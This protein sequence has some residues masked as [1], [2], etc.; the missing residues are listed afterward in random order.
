MTRLH[1]LLLKIA[2]LTLAL[3]AAAAAQDYP[4]KPVRLIVP[5][6]PG[7]LNDVVGR[8]VAMQLSEKLG[9]K[10]IVENRT[11]AGGVVGTEMLANAA[12]DGYTLGITSIA[13]AVHPAL[14]KLSYDSNKAFAPVAF[15]ASIPNAFAV[16]LK[17]PANSVKEFIALAK[18]KPGQLQYVS[19]GAGGSLHLAFELFKDMAGIDVLHI[20]FKGANPA[21][22]NLVGGHSDA[23][24]GSVSSV[25]PHIRAGKVRGLA[26]TSKQRSSALPDT[27][28]FAEAGMPDYGGGNWIGISAPAGTPAPVI[29]KLNKAIA[30]ILK[31]PEVQK[32][33]EARG[34]TADIMSPAEFSKHIDSETA[35][36]GRV[37][38]A[39]GIKAE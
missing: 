16:S 9:K 39:T 27:P 24:I 26:V 11:G 29:E 25:A 36:W 13:N 1:N 35:I 19:G 14:Y 33:L 4:T 21:M 17:V 3:T 20:P 22:I 32:Q 30:E 28:T 23:V 12:R 2:A 10:F 37:V 18:Q 34:A 38:K 15:V 8:L 31:L 6:S 7:G 5:F